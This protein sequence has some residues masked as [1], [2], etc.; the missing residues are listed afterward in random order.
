MILMGGGRAS[1]NGWPGRQGTGPQSAD[2]RLGEPEMPVKQWGG[3]FGKLEL[4][5]VDLID[6]IDGT[7]VRKG[8][9]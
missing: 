9:V 6:R 7:D 4:D 1:L 3:F 5:F 8:G 2:G